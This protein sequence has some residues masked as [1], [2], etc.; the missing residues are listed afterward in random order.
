MFRGGG[1]GGSKQQQCS[2]AS[3]R[4]NEKSG[5]PYSKAM[6]WLQVLTELCHATYIQCAI[7]AR[8]CAC[9]SQVVSTSPSKE[10]H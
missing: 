1:G 8:S 7:T 6:G 5:I 9:G 3:D 4:L 2:H 10:V